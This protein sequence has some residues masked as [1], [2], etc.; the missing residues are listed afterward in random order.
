MAT[1][2]GPGGHNSGVKNI[3]W[4]DEEGN[5]GRLEGTSVPTGSGYR[6][7]CQFI[8]TDGAAATTLYIN[9]GNATTADFKAVDLS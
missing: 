4:Y 5:Y 6:K 9:V 8:K 2:P 7:G 3:V 1:V